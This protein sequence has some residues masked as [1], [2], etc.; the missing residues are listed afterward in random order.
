MPKI[1]HKVFVV[2]LTVFVISLALAHSSLV[3]KARAMIHE[4][5][6]SAPAVRLSPASTDFGIQATGTSSP[7]RTIT[8]TNTGT[9]PLHIS[10]LI[11]TGG[12]KDDFGLNQNCPSTLAAGENCALNPIFVPTTPGPHKSTIIITDNA[13]G[14]PQSMVL[15]GVGT[16]LSPSETSL[17]FGG[18]S[19]GAS[20]SV[21]AITVTNKGSSALH[22]A[23]IAILGTDAG[24]FSLTSTC[25]RALGAGAQCTVSVTFKP[26]AKGRRAASLRFSDEGG[27]G[28]QEIILTGTGTGPGQFMA[29]TPDK[30]HLIN[31]F[32]NKPVFITGEAAWS[33]IAQPSDAD[34]E[35]YLADRAARGF[36][37]IIV[38][39]IEHQYADHAPADFSGDAP[40]IGATFS[41]PN[42]AYF[43]HADHVISRA[44]AHG[45]SVFLFPAYLG[46]GSR[47]CNIHNEGWGTDME[48]ASE[49]VMRAWGV[50]VGNRYKSFPNIIYVIGCDADPRTCSP[51]LM[52]NLNAVATGIKSVDSVHLMTADNAGQQSSLDVWSGYLWLDISDMYGASNVAKLNLEYT[53]SD[54]LPFFQGEDTYEGEGSATPL[55]LRHRQYWSVL[56]GAYLGS[57]F[58]NNPIWCFNETNPAS[59]VPCPSSPTWQSQLGSV[60]AIGQS[61][62][63]KLFR[64]REHWLLAPDINH[65]VVTA[66]YGSGAT[67]TTTART[68]NGQTIIAYVP[69]GSAATL[70]VNMRKISSAS[71]LAKCWWFNPSNGYAKLIGSFPNSGTRDFTPPDSNNWVLVI[72]DARANLAAPGT[73]DL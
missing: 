39:L 69:N 60:G 65:T 1:K 25:D 26:I 32:T 30:T 56:S 72:D 24:D 73:A 67:L 29:L 37:A 40:F 36:N 41:T 53:R 4:K 6:S 64:S 28:L 57:F 49:T 3:R 9:A 10:N 68:R 46:Y 18:Q 21:K 11:I 12:D 43:A 34:A 35:T 47:Q 71:S 51:S 52:G 50:Y 66:G 13:E 8:L 2:A 63:G 45:I 15:A 7:R 44:A 14:N 17:G 19:V 31:T 48:R 23:R 38:N 61:W 70:K 20:S 22:L 5:L 62:F 58:G 59:A 33:L 16:T 27:S 54:F 42:E 55:S